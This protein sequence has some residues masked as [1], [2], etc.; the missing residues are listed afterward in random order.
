MTVSAMRTLLSC[1]PTALAV[2]TS[3]V[4]VFRIGVPVAADDALRQQARDLEIRFLE[5]VADAKKIEAARQIEELQKRAGQGVRAPAAADEEAELAPRQARERAFVV[6]LVKERNVAA[7]QGRTLMIFRDG[8]VDVIVEAFTVEI[9]PDDDV[10][11]PRDPPVTMQQYRIADARCDQMVFGKGRNEAAARRHLDV[12]LEQQIAAIHEACELTESQSQ[13]LKLAGRGD[14]HRLFEQILGM[15]VKIAAAGD[16][17]EGDQREMMNRVI[18]L[19]RETKSLRCLVEA[20]PFFKDSLFAKARKK[21]LT[22]A[23]TARLSLVKSP[24][25]PTN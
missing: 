12:R 17:A 1:R 20:G 8:G 14:I 16:V 5:R 18:A 2:A 24:S 4:L 25:A 13:K 23:Q 21:V 7:V 3:L 19:S 11:L 6:R 15:Q 22:P 10:G 9:G